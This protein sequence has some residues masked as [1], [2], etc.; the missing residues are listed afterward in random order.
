MQEFSLY[1]KLECPGRFTILDSVTKPMLGNLT[2]SKINGVSINFESR[3]R[4]DVVMS[5]ETTI[6]GELFDLPNVLLSGVTLFLANESY[7]M[8]ATDSAKLILD[9]KI[10]S[11]HLS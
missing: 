7:E 8:G 2:Y 9:P 4:L 10:K 11:P 6:H 3:C 1:E 5:S